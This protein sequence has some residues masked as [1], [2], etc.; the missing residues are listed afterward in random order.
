M[1]LLFAL[2]EAQ[3]SFHS[4]AAISKQHPFICAS[5]PRI[6]IPCA[7]PCAGEGAHASKSSNNPCWIVHRCAPV[8]L[9]LAQREFNN[10][11]SS[12]SVA[13]DAEQLTHLLARCA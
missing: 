10:R 8:C 7:H 13:V 12:E 11:M 9:E 3:L 1:V 5:M 4:D 2:K 6:R